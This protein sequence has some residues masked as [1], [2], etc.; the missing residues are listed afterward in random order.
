MWTQS[1]SFFKGLPEPDRPEPGSCIERHD[2]FELALSIFILV[3]MVVSYLPQKIAF[4]RSHAHLRKFAF[5]P[6]PTEEWALSLKISQVVTGHLVICTAVTVALLA[7][8]GGP[9]NSWVSSWA[10]FLG[11]TS[12]TLAAIQYIPQIHRTYRR[13]SVGALS[14]PMMLMQTPGAALLTLSLALRPGANWTTWIVY[15]VTGCLQGILLVLCIIYHF[16]AKSHGQSDFVNSETAPLLGSVG[17]PRSNKA[18]KPQTRPTSAGA[19]SDH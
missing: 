7:F 18:V 1:L 13:K 16:K 3:G 10:T 4:E 2:D 6:A 11:I 17:A 19:P 8:V 9:E 5:L 14:I 12:V 15:A